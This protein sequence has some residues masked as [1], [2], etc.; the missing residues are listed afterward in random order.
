[1][2]AKRKSAS[3]KKASA[4]RSRARKPGANKAEALPAY[5]WHEGIAIALGGIAILYFLALVSYTPRD[6]PSWVPW[7]STSGVKETVSNFIGPAGALLAGCSYFLFGAAC[8]LIPGVLVWW[9]IMTLLGNRVFQPRN[10]IALF[11]LVVSATCL[12]EYQDIFF[13]AWPNTLQP[14]EQCR[15]PVRICHRLQAVRQH[16]RH[17]RSLHRRGHRLLE[18]R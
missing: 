15:R 10:F 18:W 6:L 12:I 8:Y 17:R 4:S 2:A 9:A 13:Q 1:M 14:A 5:A 11:A 3:R 7:S 16:R